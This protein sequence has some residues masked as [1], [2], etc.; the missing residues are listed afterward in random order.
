MVPIMKPKSYST[1]TFQGDTLLDHLLHHRGVT[2]ETRDNFLNPSYDLGLN[3]PFL[4]SDMQ[5]AVDRIDTAI[6]KNEKIMI[7]S[8][9]DADG[10]PGAVVL[11]DFFKMICYDNVGVYIPHRHSEGFGLNPEAIDSISIN[12]AK[13]LITI[14]CGITDVEEVALANE[15]GMDV[16]ITDHHM[17]GPVLPAAF[18]I[19]N[20][21]TSPEYP[22]QMIC[23]SGTVFKLVQ[24]MLKKNRRGVPEGKEKWLLDMVGI[25]TLSDM[26][27]LM[28]ENRV[29]AS[30]GLKV[31]RKSP[32]VGLK[33]LLSSLKISQKDL[34][35]DDIGFMIT[36]RINVASRMGTPM[37]AFRLLSTT[38][39]IEAEELVTMLNGLNNERK[40]AVG[41]IVKEIQHKID[42]RGLSEKKVIVLGNP[43][44]RPAVLG[45]V[46]N[47]LMREHKKPVFLWGRAE[48][49]T[50][51]GSCRS[52]GG[53]DVVALMH[54]VTENIF[55]DRGGHKMSGGFSVLT[56]NIHLL[57]DALQASYETIYSDEKVAEDELIADH[58]L[59]LEDIDFRLWDIVDKLSPFGTGNAK[60]VFLFKSVVPSDVKR[61]GKLQE[62][63]DIVFTKGNGKKVSAIAFFADD[64]HKFGN[65]RAGEPIDL[66]ATLEKSMFKSFPELRLRIVDI[67]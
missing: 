35:E 31:L 59:S 42:S 30:Y 11:S 2:P 40:G 13:L 46:A 27:P 39:G 8:D 38:D 9:Y 41:A 58:L 57:E 44:W 21:K 12:S 16:I 25:A 64:D 29:L 66:V 23:G 22:D 1:R 60:P 53:T 19:V 7:F 51:K 56:E 43:S 36:P 24:G 6:S 10:I 18:A 49:D 45:L 34:T 14:D 28:G 20:P 55:L 63:V 5:K 15:L 62:H 4:L 65:L 61:F 47:T 17:P 48:D 33:K 3:D 52:E 50:L 32:R 37:D 26:V 54:G 67:I